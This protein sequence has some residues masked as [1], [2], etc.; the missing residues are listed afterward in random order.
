MQKSVFSPEQLLLQ[1][2]LRRA[3]RE[4]GLRQVDLAQRLG[5][6]QPFVSRYEKGEKLLDLPELRQ[7]CRA[8]GLFLPEFVRRYEE[9]LQEAGL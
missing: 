2:L 9:A 5:K 8:L 4:A 3:R 7:V 6:P 1:E